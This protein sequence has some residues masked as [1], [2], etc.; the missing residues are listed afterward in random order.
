MITENFQKGELHSAWQLFAG[1]CYR[2]GL[3][4]SFFGM[5]ES[6]EKDTNHLCLVVVKM[7]VERKHLFLGGKSHVEKTTATCDP[8]CLKNAKKLG[9]FRVFFELNTLDLYTSY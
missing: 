6:M 4:Q 5:L 9:I 3:L 1:L 2:R 7:K 8:T